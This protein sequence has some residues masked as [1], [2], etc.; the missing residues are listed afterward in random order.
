ME[1]TIGDW[2]EKGEQIFEV[3][4]ILETEYLCR[5]VAYKDERTSKLVYGDIAYLK[6]DEVTKVGSDV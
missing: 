4:A 2:V 1:I 3:R 5:E 6:K